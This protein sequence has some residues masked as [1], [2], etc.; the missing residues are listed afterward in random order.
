[1]SVVACPLFH[2]LFRRDTSAKCHVAVAGAIDDDFSKNSFAATFTFGD[3]AFD[4][5]AVHHDVRAVCV[6]S[7]IDARFGKHFERDGFDRF[8]LDE[9]DAHVKRAGAMFARALPRFEA[10]NKFLRKPLMI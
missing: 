9:R 7:Y 5:I 6:K 1:M 3:D 8:R 2:F 10:I 4:F